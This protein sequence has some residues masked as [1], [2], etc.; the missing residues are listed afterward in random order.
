MTQVGSQAVDA[1]VL[2]PEPVRISRSV[3]ARRETV[4]KAWSKAEHVKHWFAPEHYTVPHATVEM[5]VGGA[6]EVCMRAPDGTDHWT[7]GSFAEVT[8]NDRLVLDLRVDGGDG[9]VLFT[10]WTEVT[11]SD[12]TCGTQLDIVQTYTVYDPAMLAAIGGAPEGWSQTLDKLARHAAHMD[13]RTGEQPTQ[14]SAVHAIFSLERT[15]DAPAA[16]VW[17]ALSDMEAKSKWFGGDPGQWESL[18]RTMDF[19]VGGTERAKG[20]WQGGMTS[21]FDAHYLDIIPNERIV[22]SYV[23]HLDERKISVSLATMELKPAGEGRTTLK[24]TEQGAFLD[25]YEDNGSREHGTGFLMDRLGASLK[26]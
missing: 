1:A 15:Y 24:I 19:R 6:F 12:T 8:P 26:D 10:A 20:R 16:R 22:Y 9:K 18:E 7:R 23:M 21:T 13:G 5:R 14:R 4:F 2:R 17:R 25:G 11:F 3:P